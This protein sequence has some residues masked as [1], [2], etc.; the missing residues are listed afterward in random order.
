MTKP[1]RILGLQ[2]V[3]VG[4]PETNALRALWSDIFGPAIQGRSRSQRGKL[5]SPMHGVL[6]AAAGLGQSIDSTARLSA[7]SNR[8]GLWVDDLPKAVEWMAANCACFAPGGICKGA[9][10]YDICHVHPKAGPGITIGDED[11][12]IELVQAPDDVIA[13]LSFL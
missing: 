4:G 9:A 11:V 10:G 12:Q 2:Q 3:A 1:F 8:I 5:G 7:P 13:T 6:P